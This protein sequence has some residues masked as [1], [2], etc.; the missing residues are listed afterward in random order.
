MLRRAPTLAPAPTQAPEGRRI[1]RPALAPAPVQDRTVGDFNIP[2]QLDI[3]IRSSP[4]SSPVPSPRSSPVPSPRSSFRKVLHEPI[5]GASPRTLERENTVIRSRSPSPIRLS[6]GS[7]NISRSVS[8]T[9]ELEREIENLLLEP[10]TEISPKPIQRNRGHRIVHRANP[11]IIALK[12]SVGKPLELN[13]KLFDFIDGEFYQYEIELFQKIQELIAKNK[14]I[15]SQV[16]QSLAVLI[17]IITYENDGYRFH[18]TKE[19]L[20]T[21]PEIFEINSQKDDFSGGKALILENESNGKSWGIS[22]QGIS[23]LFKKNTT[24]STKEYSE[25]ELKTWNDILNE[26][27]TNI[28]EI[29]SEKH[30]KYDSNTLNRI[31]E[32]YDKLEKQCLQK[33]YKINEDRRKE[34]KAHRLEFANKSKI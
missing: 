4:R 24:A 10:K 3:K 23:Y 25:K 8:P 5:S 11:E 19:F 13:E 14:T 28:A 15:P 12:I 27:N 32:K 22:K 2:E 7:P 17:A 18:Y 31:N 34:I 6:S 30:S 21:F 33:L 26:I 20:E 9:E 16:L 1:I 29:K